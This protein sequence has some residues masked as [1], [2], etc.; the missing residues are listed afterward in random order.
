M[1]K[2]QLRDH[3]LQQLGVLGAGQNASAEDAALIETIIDNVQDKLEHLGVAL[4]PVTD[5]PGY[6][7]ED[8]TGM[9]ASRVSAFGQ[10]PDLIKERYHEREL[11][12]LT[13]DPRHGVG[14]AEYF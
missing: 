8:F 6:A 4:W 3:V 14:K 2:A 12:R 9:V 1:N 10:T 11:R 13:N 5:V 7:I